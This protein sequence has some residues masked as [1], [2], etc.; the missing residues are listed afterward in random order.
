MVH[1]F[2]LLVR[3]LFTLLV[4]MCRLFL[5]YLSFTCSFFLSARLLIMVVVSFLILTSVLFRIIAP[6]PWLVLA[7]GFVI[8][9]VSE[10]LTGYIFL[11]LLL[12][13]NRLLMLMPHLLSSLPPPALLS[14]IIV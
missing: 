10:S 3:A 11:Q 14:G 4:F 6:G 7:I 13:A 8:L 12:R 5:M 2:L 1:L 9:L